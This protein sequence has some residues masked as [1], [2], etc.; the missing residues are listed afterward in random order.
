MLVPK[1]RSEADAVR[2]RGTAENVV[3][4]LFRV[5]TLTDLGACLA[6]RANIPD[7]LVEFGGSHRPDSCATKTET[8]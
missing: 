4:P 6:L 7:D 5:L 2:D 3:D 1:M 8:G